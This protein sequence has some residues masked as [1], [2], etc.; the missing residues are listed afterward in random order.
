LSCS[1][2]RGSG[3]VAFGSFPDVSAG[4]GRLRLETWSLDE[5]PAVESEFD[6]FGAGQNTIVVWQAPPGAPPGSTYTIT[7][8]DGCQAKA[9]IRRP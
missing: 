6:N 4:P 9:T 1:F 8:A 7:L 2:D 3:S 5:H